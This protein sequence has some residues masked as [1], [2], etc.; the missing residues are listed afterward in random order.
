MDHWRAWNCSPSEISSTTYNHSI[1]F[2]CKMS[3]KAAATSCILHGSGYDELNL[4]G[5]DATPSQ[6][7]MTAIGKR[8]L[9]VLPSLKDA[10]A[11]VRLR[12]PQRASR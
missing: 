8:K 10:V 5:E 6:Y 11:L 9:E 2:L 7:E 1:H 12:R 3:M 4:S